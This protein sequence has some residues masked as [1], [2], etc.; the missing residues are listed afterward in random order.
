MTVCEKANAAGAE[1]SVDQ[2]IWMFK[3]RS[4]ILH[5]SMKWNIQLCMWESS[6]LQL[7]I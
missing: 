3:N 7:N 2:N 4:W 6:L 1:V 5:R